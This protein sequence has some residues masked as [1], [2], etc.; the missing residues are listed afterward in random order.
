[1]DWGNTVYI[2][3]LSDGVSC[4]SDEQIDTKIDT[5]TGKYI[6]NEKGNYYFET[7]ETGMGDR[8]GQ[9]L[10]ICTFSKCFGLD[11]IV[12][13]WKNG[14]HRNYDLNDVKRYI[15]FPSNCIITDDYTLIKNRI[16]L[17][18]NNKVKNIGHSY[19]LIP[20][21]SYL[22]MIENYMFKTPVSFCEYLSIYTNIANELSISDSI[23]MGNTLP[24]DE[25]KCV[26]VRRDDKLIHPNQPFIPPN[27]IQQIESDENTTFLFISDDVVPDTI[28]NTKN[29]DIFT[30]PNLTDIEKVILDL[31]I[32]VNSSEIISVIY[33]DGWSSFSYVASRTKN[34][35][36]VSYVPTYSRHHYIC[37]RTGLTKLH[38]WEIIY[39]Q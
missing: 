27:L 30:L 13:I 15:S 29:C 7:G 18:L 35:K 31:Y 37:N 12:I 14:N 38:N 21:P 2:D 9:I 33:Q 22:M 32:L 24:V 16:P 5:K 23:L 6:I 4:I 26:H 10:T 20:E 1:M 11:N 36:L 8:M 25:Y 34:I 3:N 39:I 28:T 17:Y 19:D